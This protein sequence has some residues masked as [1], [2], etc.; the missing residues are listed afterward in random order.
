MSPT[1]AIR[2]ATPAD[3]EAIAR[4]HVH[5]WRW[6]YRDLLPP[7]YLEALS[8]HERTA[9]WRRWLEERRERR[10]AVFVAEEQTGQVV[11][12]VSAGP[13][14]D[15]D[16]GPTTGEVYA[17]YLEERAAGTGVGR[18]LF[19][20]AEGELS[21]RRFTSA[22]LWVLAANERARR[23][24]ERAGWAVDGHEKHEPLPNGFVLHEVRYAAAL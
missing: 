4:V 24:Y 13:A 23:F 5:A 18:A 6:A 11:G 20:R 3:A 19:E 12:F 2:A 8:A 9:R 1:P 17:I 22:T 14:R 16:A 7:D 10:L 21:A 15:A